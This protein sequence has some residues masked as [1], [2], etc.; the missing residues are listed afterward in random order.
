MRSESFLVRHTERIDNPGGGPYASFVAELSPPSSD[1]AIAASSAQL[2]RLVTLRAITE[3]VEK[4]HVAVAKQTDA[5]EIVA[6]LSKFHSQILRTLRL[7]SSSENERVEA[8]VLRVDD[9]YRLVTFLEPTNPLYDSF[10]PDMSLAVDERSHLMKPAAGSGVATYCIYRALTG[11]PGV[12]LVHDV[13]ST[14]DVVYYRLQPPCSYAIE[15]EANVYKRIDGEAP[16]YRSL[17]CT[18]V[19]RVVVARPEPEA[20]SFVEYRHALSITSTL[21]AAFS[22]HDCA[23]IEGV[24]SLLGSLYGSHAARAES[25]AT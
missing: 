14:P 9:D 3:Y 25:R 24:A 16:P 2:A 20:A 13:V 11:S 23:W 6:L 7:R 18:A 22:V 4:F 8:H 15:S 17:M 19:P 5:G 12:A 10:V 21:P 1:D